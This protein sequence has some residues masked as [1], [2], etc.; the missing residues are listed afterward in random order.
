MFKQLQIGFAA[1]FKASKFILKNELSWFYIMPLVINLLLFL[2]TVYGSGFLTE[3]ITNWVLERFGL[4]KGGEYYESVGVIIWWF[5]YVIIKLMSWIIFHFISGGVMLILLSPVLAYLSERTEKILKGNVYSFNLN[6][7]IKDAGRGA[8]LAVRNTILQLI[9]MAAI[10]L[11]TLIPLIQFITPF[12]LFIVAAYY[13]GF[14]FMDYTC[15]RRRL[16]L[17][18]SMRFMR[19]NKGLTL[20]N[21]SVFACVIMLPWIGGLLAGFVAINSVVAATIAVYEAEDKK[22][23]KL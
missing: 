16:T 1:Y 22:L 18:E 14:S 10:I 3:G 8:I 2:A 17:K 13:Y 7:F 19:N 12:L 9:I 20:A 6:L 23:L 5:F 11:L 4:E 15:E 21:G